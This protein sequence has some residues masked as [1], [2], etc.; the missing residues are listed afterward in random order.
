[1]IAAANKSVTGTFKI[2]PITTSIILGGINIPKVP[3]AVI[4]PAAKRTSY[5]ALFIVLADIIPRIVTDAP[6]IPVAA[7][8]IVDTKSTA[9]NSEPLVL[10][11]AIWTDVN[12]L[13]IKFAFSIIIP[14]KVNK[15]IA[16]SVCSNML[17][18]K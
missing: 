15:G 2:G 4:E 14:M 12:S 7:P 6:T 1:M 5:F 8:N 13:S 9:T 16:A 10:D 11:N 3:P 17:A 18:E